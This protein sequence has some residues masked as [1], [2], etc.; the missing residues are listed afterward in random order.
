MQ[1]I[2]DRIFSN[3]FVPYPTQEQTQRETAIGFAILIVLTVIFYFIDR[4]TRS[5][6]WSPLLKRI[7]RILMW[8]MYVLMA[9][10][11]G[12]VI[13]TINVMYQR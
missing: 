6:K 7:L 8:L 2:R 11:I 12:L 13:Y 3:T 5:R 4:F 1:N 9:G 10:F